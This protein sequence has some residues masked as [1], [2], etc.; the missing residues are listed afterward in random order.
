MKNLKK[1]CDEKIIMLRAK[2]TEL[3]ASQSILNAKYDELK[4]KYEEL[5]SFNNKQSN[6]LTNNEI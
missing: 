1:K 4:K 2:I 3:N 5:R 6:E